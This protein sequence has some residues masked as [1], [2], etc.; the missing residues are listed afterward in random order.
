MPQVSGFSDVIAADVWGSLGS[1]ATGTQLRPLGD[2]DVL[3][4][5]LT[6]VGART[7]SL[8]FSRLLRMAKSG[9]G[10]SL[11]ISVAEHD[12]A[13]VR[14]V[15]T[16][17]EALLVSRDAL[18]VARPDRDLPDLKLTGIGV[19][20]VLLVDAGRFVSPHAWLSHTGP[21]ELPPETQTATGARAASA[22][23]GDTAADS[24]PVGPTAPQAS[25][26]RE[27]RE[28]TGLPAASLGAALGVTREQ[29]QRWL[30]GDPISNI[31][32]GQ[33]AYLHTIAADATRR[34]GDQ[35]L[36]WWRT[37][38]EG[39]AT[40]EQM[41][42]NRLIDRVHRL[43]VHLPDSAPVVDGV[44]VALAAQEPMNLDD[45]DEPGDDADSPSA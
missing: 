15:A 33:L 44:L 4:T 37:P 24:E 17:L 10:V 34:L 18:E 29:Y 21:R 30:R 45:F 36:V 27:L 12:T 1:V 32:H 7:G 13:A 11:R 2:V 39:A 8:P 6:P 42:R 31:R 40:P 41:L 3:I 22:G 25:L 28:L 38:A 23:V 5:G 26:A 20:D 19:G 16:H 9:R 43:V 35:A 14:H